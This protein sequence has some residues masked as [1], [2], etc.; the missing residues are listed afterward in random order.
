M[1]HGAGMSGVADKDCE[2][3]IEDVRRALTEMETYIDVTEKDLMSI[4]AL[5]TRYARERRSREIPIAQLMTS[6]VTTISQDADI[7]EAVNLLSQKGV[8]GLPV[9]DQENHVIGIITEADVLCMTGAERRHGIMDL[10]K[11][12]LGE[13][14]LKQPK[15]GKVG[16]FMTA[17]V[18]LIKDDAD[19]RA[20]ARI[21]VDKRI[22]RLPVVDAQNRL[23]GIITRADIVRGLGTS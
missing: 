12:L 5:A 17:P 18:A 15:E 10:V 19:A 20:A 13:P 11:Q 22:K 7:R 9:V 1:V 8:S 16:D 4:Y 6:S 2:I 21:M 14:C 23:V 3:T